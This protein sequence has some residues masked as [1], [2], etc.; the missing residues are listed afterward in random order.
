MKRHLIQGGG[1]LAAALT[2]TFS[3]QAQAR[4]LV[5]CQKKVFQSPNSV[6]ALM[7]WSKRYV[8][9]LAVWNDPNNYP[10]A[11]CNKAAQLLG[12]AY[13]KA[14]NDPQVNASLR[15]VLTMCK[16]WFKRARIA[17]KARAAHRRPPK[18]AYSP[19]QI[20]SIIRK[21]YRFIRLYLRD[22]AKVMRALGELYGL[23]RLAPNHPQ[24]T[25]LFDRYFASYFGM[26]VQEA[27]RLRKANLFDERLK[28]WSDAKRRQLAIDLL[29][30]RLT[31][32]DTRRI[33]VSYVDLMY[34]VEH[35]Y[36]KIIKEQPEPVKKANCAVWLKERRKNYTL[37]ALNQN[38]RLCPRKQPL[39]WR[40]VWLH[41]RLR[42]AMVKVLAK[43]LPNERNILAQATATFAGQAGAKAV[44]MCWKLGNPTAAP[45]PAQVGMG[46]KAC[47]TQVVGHGQGQDQYGR[48]M[49][50]L[51]GFRPKPLSKW[52]GLQIQDA[53]EFARQSPMPDR[54]L[55]KKLARAYKKAKK[56][57]C[58]AFT[59]TM[60]KPK[61]SRGWGRL[62][63]YST[64]DNREIACRKAKKSRK[65]V[66]AMPGNWTNY[67]DTVIGGKFTGSWRTVYRKAY[68][69]RHVVDVPVRKLRPAVIYV[70][71][72]I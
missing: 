49:P 58:V 11:A 70:R 61:M 35:L 10:L 17:Q 68:I 3:Y 20:N 23:L 40:R 62:A 1:V 39:S 28:K 45:V 50:F 21:Q 7:G 31:N 12:S 69:H 25:A 43:G 67:F 2:L 15:K 5:D 60:Q 59:V 46:A 13:C 36:D 34:I 53:L 6:R 38:M 63:H 71:R 66:K 18:E 54:G 51:M 72:K 16:A 24:L 52:T 27:T 55:I 14:P 26:T 42:L 33:K 64:G 4:P 44:P 19:A 22:P 9:G 48:R 37:A 41:P 65:F 29:L 8:Q 47:K 32:P 30:G 56:Y 57:I